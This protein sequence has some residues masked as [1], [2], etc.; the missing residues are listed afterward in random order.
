MSNKQQGFSLIETLIYIGLFAIIMSGIIAV[1]Y[2]IFE[3]SGRNQTKTMVQE[4]GNFLL[5]KINW[6]LTGATAINQPA[7]GNSD[8]S[9]NTLTLT[10]G[11]SHLT[12]SLSGGNL[13]LQSAVLNNS[14]ITVLTPVTNPTFV[15]THTGTGSNPESVTARFTLQTKTPNGQI[16][17]QDFQTTKY[18]R[19]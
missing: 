12:F 6:A 10:K 8:N 5:A 19:K 16:Y 18:L 2:A 4:E 1:A 13:V 3:S 9:D 11:G 7:S 15:F 14:N 17:T